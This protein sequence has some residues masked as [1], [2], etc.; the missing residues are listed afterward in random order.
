MILIVGLLLFGFP[1][2][3][4][5]FSIIVRSFYNVQQIFFARNFE[6]VEVLLWLNFHIKW[7]TMCEIYIC[8]ILVATIDVINVLVGH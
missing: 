2:D 1:V 3:F 5:Y 4:D 7:A 6:N 8:S